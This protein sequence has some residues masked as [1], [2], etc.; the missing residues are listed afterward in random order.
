[1]EEARGELDSSGADWII[2]VTIASLP[3]GGFWWLR[4]ALTEGPPA[5]ALARLRISKPDQP[6]KQ[7]EGNLP[8][9][10]L[11]DLIDML[12]EPDSLDPAALTKVPAVYDGAPCQLAILRRDPEAA[13]TGN[14]N[15]GGVT[16][17]LRGLPAVCLKLAG[18]ARDFA[19]AP[20][21]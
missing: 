20:E 14:C 4:L 17:N 15:L 10:A 21:G 7:V 12:K 3:Y 13:V 9:G 11:K 5:R 1:M 18:I 6:D 2:L 19:A 16:D 8:D